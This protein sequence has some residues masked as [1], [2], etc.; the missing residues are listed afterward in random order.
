V[1]SKIWGHALDTSAHPVCT[2]ALLEA[3]LKDLGRPSPPHLTVRLEA[4]YHHLPLRLVLP[5][6]S[7]DL[8]LIRMSLPILSRH[9]CAPSKVGTARSSVLLPHR[10]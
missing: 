10:L 8:F 5:E 2:Y 6:V 9:P 1:F 7:E 3:Y 4:F